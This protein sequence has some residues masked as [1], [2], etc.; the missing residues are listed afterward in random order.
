MA[1]HNTSNSRPLFF[2][3][4]AFYLTLQV[5]A[6]A[7]DWVCWVSLTVRFSWEANTPTREN[8]FLS[9]RT[10]RNLRLYLDHC[11]QNSFELS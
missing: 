7:L 3:M 11:Q 1:F 4:F 5:W 10:R 6:E 2:R 8:V 9:F